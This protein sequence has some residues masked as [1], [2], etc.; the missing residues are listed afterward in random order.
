MADYKKK[1]RFWYEYSGERLRVP[2]HF[3]YTMH[4]SKGGGADIGE[5][6]FTW[7]FNKHNISIV[8][9]KILYSSQDR[10]VAEKNN[11]AASNT[12]FVASVRG[13]DKRGVE[14]VG[15][16]EVGAES[17][18]KFQRGYPAGLAIKRAK[19]NMGKEF[20][21]LVDLNYA[22]DCR[23]STVEFGQDKGKTL[24]TLAQT[25]NGINTIRWFASEKFNGDDLFKAKAQEFL[26]LYID[27]TGQT[28]P[29]NQ[30]TTS[31]SN[32]T[33]QTIPTTSHQVQ[34]SSQSMTHAT[35]HQ[36]VKMSK[37]QLDTMGS[38]RN[39]Y[40]LTNAQITEIATQLFGQGF[41]WKNA[42]YDQGQA[43]L[44]HLERQFGKL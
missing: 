9:I 3:V 20:F 36:P 37:E 38:Y 24:E 5:A 35:T 29:M 18:T 43:F 40:F 41:T 8:D 13:K 6:F 16:G 33:N 32:Q 26:S 12:F 7:A 2:D 30:V 11:T 23:D 21:N 42:T 34:T 10:S 15:D 22:T 1:P 4:E 28:Q 31:T 44:S 17:I 27:K 39:K 25:P 19:V 14:K